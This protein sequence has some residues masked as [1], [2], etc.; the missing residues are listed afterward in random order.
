MYQA[1]QWSVSIVH[2]AAMFLFHDHQS[3]TTSMAPILAQDFRTCFS[4]F[5]LIFAQ[6]VLTKRMFLGKKNIFII[7]SFHTP[8]LVCTVSKLV[9]WP[10]NC[11][12][13]NLKRLLKA[14]HRPWIKIRSQIKDRM[15]NRVQPSNYYFNLICLRCLVDSKTP[16]WLL[17]FMLI[18]IESYWINV[19]FLFV[20]L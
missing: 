11:N 5:I 6:N 15:L 9:R 1:N 8:I 3:T 2:A 10:I 14:C 18:F 13:I 12:T 19:G 16:M 7:A 20:W 17:F 4:L